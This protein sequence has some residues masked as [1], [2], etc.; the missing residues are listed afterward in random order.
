MTFSEIRF[1]KAENALETVGFRIGATMT[2]EAVV[3]PI[4]ESCICEGI[5][6][7]QFGKSNHFL[8]EDG[9]TTK[10]PYRKGLVVDLP[11]ANRKVWLGPYPTSKCPLD[12]CI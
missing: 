1:R 7:D 5:I 12:I 8:S 4:Y 3:L 9:S 11:K 10:I 2:W 6:S